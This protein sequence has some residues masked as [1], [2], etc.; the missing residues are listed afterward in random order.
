MQCGKR[1][2]FYLKSSMKSQVKIKMLHNNI[3]IFNNF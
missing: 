2:D 3:C 1:K